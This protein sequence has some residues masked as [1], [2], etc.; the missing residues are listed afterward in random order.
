M[1]Y[2]LLP[3]G[4]ICSLIRFFYKIS[5][6]FMIRKNRAW[7]CNSINTP[8]G[9]YLFWQSLLIHSQ[10][11]PVLPLSLQP[12]PL[13]YILLPTACRHVPT[14]SSAMCSYH[15]IFIIFRRRFLSN[16]R[17]IFSTSFNPSQVSSLLCIKIGTTVPLNNFTFV[18]KDIPRLYQ[19]F[20]IFEKIDPAFPTRIP[21]SFRTIIANN[22]AQ[23][24]K[25]IHF[26]KHISLQFHSHIF[27]VLIS[28]SSCSSSG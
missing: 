25:W 6:I 26:N 10:S 20:L 11:M 13:N 21:T 8:T 19:T 1:L 5:Y 28:S 23:I 15:L 14:S 4:N 18:F 3:F 27:T 2:F 17:S 22:T 12:H 16:T 9:Q 24:L 7:V